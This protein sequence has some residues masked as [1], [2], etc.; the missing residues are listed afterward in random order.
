L[1]KNKTITCFYTWPFAR[2]CVEHPHLFS[3][4]LHNISANLNDHIETRHSLGLGSRDKF[5]LS[6]IILEACLKYI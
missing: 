3:V 5:Q 2:A 4:I 1:A 6:C